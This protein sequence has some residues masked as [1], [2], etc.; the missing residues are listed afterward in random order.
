MERG[1]PGERYLLGGPNW[2]FVEFF[3]RLERLSKVSGPRVRAPQQV[4]LFGARIVDAIYRHL[5]RVPPVE[6]AS[7]EM[8]THYWYLDD[9][10]ARRELDFPSYGG[11]GL[12]EE[13]QGAPWSRI[14]DEVYREHGA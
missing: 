8:A 1:R 14:R 7:V 10:K 11:K 5:D 6:Y 12:T 3:G 2:T 13:F 9:R 4:T